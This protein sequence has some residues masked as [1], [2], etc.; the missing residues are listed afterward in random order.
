MEECGDSCTHIQ[1]HTHIHTH[2]QPQLGERT[3][4]RCGTETLQA[5]DFLRGTH[6]VCVY[7]SLW[8]LASTVSVVSM[9]SVVPMVSG[10]Y[11]LH[12]PYD[13]YDLWSL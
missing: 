5:S 13:L 7:F 3:A 11:G 10:L 2:G 9:V 12:G 1:A 8:S 6:D 4:V